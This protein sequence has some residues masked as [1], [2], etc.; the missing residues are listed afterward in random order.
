MDSPVALVTPAKSH[1]DVIVQAVAARDRKRA[2][3]YAKKHGI[4]VVK[5]S[6]QGVCQL[7]RIL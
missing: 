2:E 7:P 5:D 6:Y 4:P 1:P 3:E